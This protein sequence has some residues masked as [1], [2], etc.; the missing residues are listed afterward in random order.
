MKII[1]QSEN[2]EDFLDSDFIMSIR[3]NIF[4]ILLRITREFSFHVLVVLVNHLL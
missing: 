4:T 3:L 2:I 1:A